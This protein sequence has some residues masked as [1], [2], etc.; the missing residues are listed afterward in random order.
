MLPLAGVLVVAVEQA[1]AAPLCTRHLGDLGARVVKVENRAGGDFARA[2]DEVVNGMAA[3]FVWANRNKES[4]ALDLKHPEGREALARLVAQADVVVQNLAPGAAARLG[5]DPAELRAKHPRLICVD[6]SGYGKGGPYAQAR[7]Y[8]LLV[9]SEAGSCAI[10]GTPEAPAKPGIPIADIGAGM[11][12]LSSILTALYVRE[13]TG[14]GAAISVGLFDVVAEWMGFAL[15]QARYGGFDVAP[16]G[17]SSPMVSPY[18]AYRTADGQTLVLG[19]TN[20]REWRRLAGHVL[21]RPDLAKDPRY[22]TNADRVALRP[23][24]DAV[25]A[26]WA[27]TL[28]LA[29]CRRLAE[30]AGLGHA[31][32]NTPTEVLAHPQ[33]T[34]RDRWQTVDSPAGPV[35][36]LLPPPQCDS[37]DWRLDAVPAL[38]AHS[39]QILADL[40][41]PPADVARLVADGVAG[42]AD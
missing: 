21:G 13:R 7:A 36:V 41:Y 1:V 3:H 15:N 35:Q 19:T 10:T 20:D 2:Y 5:L 11:Y 9:Q 31:R 27:A 42:P 38:G 12:A 18:G 16:N 26:A 24:L 28:P 40:G 25:I 8:D 29:E 39:A 34:D 32:L 14:E 4:L 30:D 23:E 17:L 6:I 22:T 37:W 33:L